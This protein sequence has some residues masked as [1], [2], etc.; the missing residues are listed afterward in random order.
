MSTSC[1]HYFAETIRGAE[2]LGL[3]GDVLL[4]E[5]GLRREAVMDPTWRGPSESLARLVQLVWLARGDE[6]M[7]FTRHPCRCGTFAMIV[8]AVFHE[9]SIEKALGKAV[10]FYGLVTE[11]IVMRVE[12]DE[13]RLAVVI[14]FAEPELDPSRYFHEFWLSIWYRLISWMGGALA[15]LDRATFSYGEPELRVAEFAHMFPTRFVFDAPETALVFE[16]DFLRAPIL[17]SRDELKTLL[18]V[19]PLGFMTTPIDVRS[20]ARQVRSLLLEA[21]RAPLSFP[22]LHEVAAAMGL[23]E[24]SLR[25]RL[26]DEATSFREIKESIR[27]ELAVEKIVQGTHSV[28]GIAELLG[29]SETRAFARAFRGWTGMSP[30]AYRRHFRKLAGPAETAG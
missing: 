13:A 6:F 26:R 16:R 19:A 9:E 27:R 15:P 20:H 24:Q 17:R 21:G 28:A 29:Y 8:H 1:S 12:A 5:V 14:R 10:R 22:S 18:S 7:G 2:R 4:A 3:N 11:D 23:G 25:R 30:S